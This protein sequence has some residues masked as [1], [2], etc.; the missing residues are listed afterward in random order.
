MTAPIRHC[1]FAR[2]KLYYTICVYRQI[3][4]DLSAVQGSLEDIQPSHSDLNFT[5]VDDDIS[6]EDN[7]TNAIQSP[8]TS[9][10]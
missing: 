10:C 9:R 5:A 2:I 7:N 4:S 3:S 8:G 1:L 6:Y